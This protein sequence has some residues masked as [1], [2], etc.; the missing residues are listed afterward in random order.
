MADP[1]VHF[2]DMIKVF[3]INGK[4]KQG[5]WP[6]PRTVL[7]TD[8]SS[9]TITVPGS[10]GKHITAAVEDTSHA[11]TDDNLAASV[12]ETINFL[13]D[14][15]DDIASPLHG[16]DYPDER[17]DDRMKK[18]SIMMIS[19]QTTMTHPAY[20]LWPSW[21]LLVTR[22]YVLFGYSI[23]G[24]IRWTPYYVRRWWSWRRESVRRRL[25]RSA[26]RQ[27]EFYVDSFAQP[28]VSSDK[29]HFRDI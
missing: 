19:T 11:I 3:A 27:R 21:N 28:R 2:S 12:I 9:G 10:N 16:I 24:W 22:F 7:S 5:N 23:P 4:E 17:I 14:T 13:S 29:R 1:Q 26:S 20:Q 8:R 15:I 25:A 6:S 18:C